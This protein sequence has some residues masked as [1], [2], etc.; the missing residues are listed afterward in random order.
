MG[1]RP[2][3]DVEGDRPLQIKSNF[4][5]NP[6]SG[7]VPGRGAIAWQLRNRVSSENLG[8]HAKIIKETRFLVWSREEG[9]S[10]GS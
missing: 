8:V 3:C 2:L 5:R 7:L 9:R 6:V 10:R 1:D 4:Q